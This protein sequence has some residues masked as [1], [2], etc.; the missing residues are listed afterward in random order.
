MTSTATASPLEDLPLAAGVSDYLDAVRRAPGPRPSTEEAR[1]AADRDA[2]RLAY[3][4]PD[5]MQVTNSYVIGD[6]R[7]TQVR[8][9]RPAGDSARAAI[10]YFHGGGFTVGSVESYDCLA[11][12][13]AEA[14]GASV[15]SVDYPRLPEATPAEMLGQCELVLDW[16]YAMAAPLDIDTNAISVAGDSAGAFL[17][18]LLAAR[19]R[20]C[21]RPPLAAQL[22]FY[23]VYDLNGARDA[24][25]R[26]NDPVLLRPVIGAMITTYRTCEARDGRPTPPPL[27][28]PDLAGLP[29]AIMLGAEYDAVLDEGREYALR[30]RAHGVAV[31]E[32]T[33]PMMC[34][35]FLRAVRF[36]QPA[37]DE[38]Q[39]VGERFRQIT[40][41]ARTR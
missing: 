34:H 7:E 5:G 39:W 28:L 21:S 3:A 29:P 32:R 27:D 24:Y 40:Q 26:A 33:A 37:R 23:G 2:Y 17:A 41:A 15:I 13:L 19:A 22:L 31:D 16:V 36:S 1:L 20:G 38:M 18:T 4:L 10:V 25:V 9:Y 35:G 11:T 14:T 30:L 8:I 6:G 12:A